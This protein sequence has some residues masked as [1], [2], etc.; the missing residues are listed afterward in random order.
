MDEP[1]ASVFVEGSRETVT[2]D[3][4]PPKQIGYRPLY[5]RS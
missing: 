1:A 2:A 5:R 3:Q 4:W